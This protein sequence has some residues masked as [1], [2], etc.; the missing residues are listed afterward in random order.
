V[1]STDAL[2]NSTLYAYNKQGL[3]VSTTNAEE[4]ETKFNYLDD[5]SPQEVTDALGRKTTFTYDV[6]GN[7]SSTTDPMGHKTKYFFNAL[8]RWIQTIDAAGNVTQYEY[9]K[10]DDLVKLTDAK[11]NKTQFSYNGRRRMVRQTY[12]DGLSEIYDYD[13]VSN[14]VRKTNADGQTIDFKYNKLN[15]LVVKNSAG[16]STF[17]SYDAAGRLIST[18]GPEGVTSFAYNPKGSV[19]TISY[20]EGRNVGYEYDALDRRTKLVYPDESF[21]LY[22]Y[23]AN[24]NLTG[25]YDNKQNA[26]AL[27]TFDR[28]GRRTSLV[29]AN[30]SRTTYQYDKADQLTSLASSFST[31][32]T[33]FDYTYDLLGNRTEIKSPRGSDRFVYDEIGQLIQATLSENDTLTYSYDKLGNRQSA[34]SKSGAIAYEVN[35]LNQYDSISGEK[36]TYD[37]NGNLTLS[38]AQKYSYDADNRLISA[39]SSKASSEYEYDIFGRRISKQIRQPENAEK[40]HY[41][42]DGT[43]MLAIYDQNGKMKSKFIYGAY[44]DEH[45]AMESGGSYYYYLSD[46]LGSIVSVLDSSSKKVEEYFYEPFGKVNEIVKFNE[47]FDDNPHFFTGRQLDSET[48][49]YF[50]R[51]RY[52]DASSGRFITR[53]PLPFQD[54]MNNYAYVKNNPLNFVDPHGTLAMLPGWVGTIVRGGVFGI[55]LVIG[56]KP[57]GITNPRPEGK[58][59]EPQRIEQPLNPP[60]KGDGKGEG[61][62][63]DK[64][65]DGKKAGEPSDIE[66]KPV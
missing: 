4:A 5:G 44:I 35:A 25:I 64:G 66:F 19:L 26:L 30:G 3:L 43:D 65:G 36:Q 33:V 59:P 48:Q 24:A 58:K 62:G 31:G 27:Y 39:I 42:Y 11:G 45:V 6:Y 10:N 14:V 8:N 23:D 15:Q 56:G 49:L 21:I 63:D 47:S 53:D 37:K 13:E 38:G 1:R 34:S 52:Y 12:A 61:K 54:G 9:D 7:L 40:E 41:L 50:Y 29:Y 16:H 32:T 28:I 55:T 18:K 46:G 20:P 57:V 51:A 60:G 22:L 2:K 17:F